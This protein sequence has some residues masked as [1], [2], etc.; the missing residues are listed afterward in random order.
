MTALRDWDEIAETG[1]HLHAAVNTS[2]GALANLQLPRADPRASPA[3]DWPSLILEI[4]EGEVVKDVALVHEIARSC[5]S[6]GLRS[7]SMISARLLVLRALRDMP[8][9]ELKLDRSFVSA[10]GPTRRTRASARRSSISPTTS[11]AGGRGASRA[12]SICKR[13]NG[14][15]GHRAGLL[16]GA[17]D[18]GERALRCCSSACCKSLLRSSN[19]RGAIVI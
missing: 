13:C 9:A 18:A 3:S 16:P 5:A 7:R 17:P 19:D 8:F 14:W 11:G 12:P 1:V 10:A 4:T 2:I 15:A 6:M